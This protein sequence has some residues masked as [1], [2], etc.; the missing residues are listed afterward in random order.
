MR[1]K[2]L[3]S[4]ED[5]VLCYRTFYQRIIQSNA[6]ASYYDRQCMYN[7]ILRRVRVT[8]VVVEKQQVLNI[9]NVCQ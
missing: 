5:I 3:F 7:V 8:R 4:T 2:F 1:Y 9:L 6:T